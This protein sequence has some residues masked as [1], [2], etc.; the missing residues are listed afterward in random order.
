MTAL[1]EARVW[2]TGLEMR[3]RAILVLGAAVL[4][5]SILYIAVI[6]P[7]ANAK[8]ALA[9]RVL[10]KQETAA[11][12]RE[13]AA[14][15]QSLQGALPKAQANTTSLL[16]TVDSTAKA[17]GLGSAVRNLQQDDNGAAVRVRLEGAAF[18]DMVSW[19]NALQRQYGVTATQLTVDR[20]DTAGAIN[21]SLSLERPVS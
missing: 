5:I 9:E 4:L 18:D 14:E 3:E 10:R 15:V 6:E 12:M 13:A 2:F 1:T 21:A 19:L 16:T 8:L 7:F 20:A 17:A 11:W